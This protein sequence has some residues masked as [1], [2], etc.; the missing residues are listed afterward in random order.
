M[1]ERKAIRAIQKLEGEDFE[2]RSYSGRG[3][4]GRYC[5]GVSI[6]DYF[7]AQEVKKLISGSRM[8]NLGMGYIVY[9]PGL[10]WPA[11]DLN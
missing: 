10:T 1:S 7:D 2:P 3:M 11:E 5:V 9:W 8:D 4:Y 6:D